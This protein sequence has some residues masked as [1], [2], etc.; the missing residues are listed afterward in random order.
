MPRSYKVMLAFFAFIVGV[1][2]LWLVAPANAMG[3][4]DA[5]CCSN[6]DCEKIH[7]TAVTMEA[8]GYHVRYHA[9]LGFDVDV[10][11]PFNAARPSRDEYYHGCAN[12]LNF[13]CLY[14]PMNT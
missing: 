4:Y 5:Q 3:W 14:V 2:F 12:T 6:R 1:I 7:D 11:V 10:V 9:K 13:L 8:G